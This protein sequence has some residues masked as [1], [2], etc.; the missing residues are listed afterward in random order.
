ALL[1]NAEDALKPVTGER[2]LRIELGI[3]GG[4]VVLRVSDTG[5]GIDRSLADS[6]FEPFVTGRDPIEHAGLGL[7]AARAIAY[8]HNGELALEPRPAGGTMMVVRLPKA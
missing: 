6:A 5:A 4:L 2:E 7:A 1:L 8:R 3:D